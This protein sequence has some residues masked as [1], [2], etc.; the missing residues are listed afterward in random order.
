V[1]S[2]KSTILATCV[3][4]VDAFGPEVD[5]GAERLFCLPRVFFFLPFSALSSAEIN[6][7]IFSERASLAV[8]LFAV[9][10][11]D[12]V[13]YILNLYL[14]AGFTFNLGRSCTLR[15]LRP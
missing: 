3:N 4:S 6:K 5:A 13:H 9:K 14:G 8:C 1:R 2:R 7:I 10:K 15:S 12:K 11:G